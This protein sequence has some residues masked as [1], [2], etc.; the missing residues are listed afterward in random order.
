MISYNDVLTNSAVSLSGR[1]GIRS[2][3]WRMRGGSPAMKCRA[4]PRFSRTS[5]RKLSISAMDAH[6]ADA[7][8]LGLDGIRLVPVIS[9]FG[10]MLVSVTYFWKGFLS[11]A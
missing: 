10:S 2:P 11:T 4:E 6:Q 8:V 3:N 7:E 5:L 9:T 1:S